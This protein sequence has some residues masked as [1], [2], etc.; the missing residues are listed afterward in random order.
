M[1]NSVS[2]TIAG[3]LLLAYVATQT[4]LA[5]DDSAQ[6]NDSLF[7][8]LLRYAKLAHAAYQDEDHMK[9]IS[10]EQGL[11]FAGA[12]TLEI[13]K[14]GYFIGTD[15]AT[16]SMIIS[17]RGTSNL[18]NAF[19][20]LNYTLRADNH[21][22][23]QLHTGFL[24]SAANLYREI[25][26]KIKDGYTVH[27]TGHSLGG[28]V[29]LIL[30]MH[31]YVDGLKVGDVVTFGQPKVTNRSGAAKFENLNV[32]RLVAEHDMVPIMPPVDISDIMNTKMDIFWHLGKAYLLLPDQYYASLEGLDSL[33]Y[34]MSLF[35][36]KLSQ[37]NIDAHRMDNYLNLIEEK[38]KRSVLIPYEERDNYV[39]T[40]K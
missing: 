3:T 18:D 4:S 26:P 8:F 39:A 12:G 1:Q 6:L 14:V 20:D 27:V 13:E 29:A 30:A 7:S 35:N 32:I 22:G 9:Q 40:P 34:G 16:K 23:I 24:Q 25:K 36:K 28:A 33:K 17:V 37:E 19:V 31:L 11:I 15:P 21:T 10:K 38:A 5:G 2:R